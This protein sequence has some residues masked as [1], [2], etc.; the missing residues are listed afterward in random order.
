MVMMVIHAVALAQPGAF[1]PYGCPMCVTN[2]GYLFLCSECIVKAAA[3]IADRRQDG[4][5]A[6]A[7]TQ[8][9]QHDG[10]DYV[11]YM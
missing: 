6:T 1:T 9:P 5:A 10:A 8:L 4:G 7:A 3:E 2:T 11:H